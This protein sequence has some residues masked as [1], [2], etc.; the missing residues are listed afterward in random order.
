M[1]L[2]RSR[3]VC[4]TAF[5]LTLGLALSLH[6]EISQAHSLKPIT[7]VEGITEYR[8]PNGLQVLLA[9]DEAKPSTTVNVTYR[10]GSKHENYGETGMA[11]LLEHLI[12]KGSPKTPDPWAEFSRRG[13]NANGTTWFDRTNYFAA[14]AAN[15]E[16]LKWY[17]QWQADAMVNSFIA[18]RH[19]DTEMTVVRNEMEM[20]ENNA[21]GVTT[22]RILA[23]M[24]Q[25]HNYGK[26]TIGARSDVENVNIQRLQAFYRAYYQPD[27]ATLTVTGKFKPDQVLDWVEQSFGKLPKSKKKPAPLYTVDPV[28][29][30][31]RLLT[32]RRVG[33]NPLSIAAYHV[34]PG[35]HPDYAAIELLN[36]ILAEAPSGR[37][38]KRLVEESKLAAAV[39][40]FGLALAE[41]GFSMLIAESAPGASQDALNRELVTVTEGFAQRP[42][43]AQELSRAKTRWLNRWERSFTSPEEVGVTLSESIAQGDWR[44]FFLLRDRIKAISLDDVQ[45]VA[46]E[47]FLPA[48]RTLA[49]YIPSEKPQR[50]PAPA[51]VNLAEQMQSFKPQPAAAPVPAF[52]ASP[53]AID[54]KTRR[55]RLPNGMQLSLLPKP[56]RGQAVQ[57]VI[58]LSLGDAQSLFGQQSVAQMTA[59]LL[60]KGT[61]SL[62]REQL[63]DALDAAKVELSVLNSE[64]GDR[65]TLSWSSKR[66]QAQQ[67]LALISQML[68]QPRL[69]VATLEEVRSQSLAAVQAQRDDPEGVAGK[70]LASALD[71]YPAGDARH[72]RSFDEEVKDHKAVTA[73]QVQAFHK[74][75]YG[76]QKAQLSMVGDFDAAAIES[77]AQQLF[78]DWVAPTQ[79]Q[80][81]P[82]QASK[83]PGR[84]QLIATPDK[85]NAMMLGTLHLPL[86]DE[87]ADRAALAMASYL[88]GGSS[89]SRLWLR[90]REKEGLSYGAGAGI[91]FSD[92]DAVSP[93]WV[94]GIFAPQNRAKV[95]AALREEL[96]RVLKDGFSP[97]ELSEAKQA[98][99]NDRRL[100]RA[101]DEALSAMLAKQADL[102]RTMAREQSFDQ[103]LNSLS[104]EQVNAALR[105][106]FR[107]DDFQLIFAGDFK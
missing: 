24:Y 38:H 80:H 6:A 45:R 52:D 93:L 10:V 46:T 31:E 87:H 13:L 76:G 55:S 11:H 29:D 68:R 4:L 67:A 96:S 42:I 51:M 100:G 97:R 104:L 105:Q 60:N 34:P 27:N 33:G 48:N 25:W 23:A 18:R 32:V 101:Q 12:F 36:L 5:S 26:D 21:E 9:P 50:A 72:A 81:L 8:L 91:R 58:S 64:S 56:S 99:L 35:A 82:R 103:A 54:A 37:L 43:T 40:N 86:N 2:F 63:R 44:L 7:S 66:E 3:A 98:L 92:R 39:R 16:N 47:R 59:S 102:D 106:Y 107:L 85:Q 62:D 74:A 19:L 65:L 30:G 73:A 69:D 70:A 84:L 75:M 83:A 61:Q 15:D 79:P 57:G 49:Q 88:V 53:A 14:F 1:P 90:I 94:Y 17:L 71:L 77:A 22:Q 95:E 41:P 20:G 28:Q 89:S 78:G